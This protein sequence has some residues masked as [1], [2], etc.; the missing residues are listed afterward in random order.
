MARFLDAPGLRP[1]ARTL[2]AGAAA[3]ILAMGAMGCSAGGTS[4]PT[5]D[6]LAAAGQQAESTAGE[7]QA[8]DTGSDVSGKSW[9]DIIGEEQRDEDGVL[10]TTQELADYIGVDASE[11]AASSPTSF[12]TCMEEWSDFNNM[13][14]AG[15]DLI[16]YEGQETPFLTTGFRTENDVYISMMIGISSKSGNF[17]LRL[18]APAETDNYYLFEDDEIPSTD[19]LATIA[20]E[21]IL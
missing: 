10:L 5:G 19:A 1:A 15:N 17:V 4:E 18:S 11:I 6:A 20:H 13:D 14:T 2:V 3:V 16:E 9:I 12:I 7:G 21:N 8:P